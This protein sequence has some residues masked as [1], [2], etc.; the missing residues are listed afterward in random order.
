MRTPETSSDLD[1]N[2][3]TVAPDRI[4]LLSREFY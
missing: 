4:E 2:S 3:L 1:F